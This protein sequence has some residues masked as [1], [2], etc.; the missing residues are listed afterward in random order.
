VLRRPKDQA[1]HQAR[2]V[3]MLAGHR[4]FPLNPFPAWAPLF[5]K[6]LRQSETHRAA[7]RMSAVFRFAKDGESKNPHNNDGIGLLRRGKVLSFAYFSLHEQRKVGRASAR[8]LLTFGQRKEDSKKTATSW[9]S[10]EKITSET[11]G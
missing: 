6:Q 4:A 9:P 8:K 1:D 2:A 7:D 3:I 5:G 11:G 10:L